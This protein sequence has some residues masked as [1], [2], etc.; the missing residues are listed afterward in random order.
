MAT[1]KLK[2]SILGLINRSPMS[3]YDLRKYFVESLSHFWNAEFNQIYTELRRLQEEG[4]VEFDT[5]KAGEKLEKKVYRI[6]EAGHKD[7]MDWLFLDEPL[8]P[9]RADS[10][11]LR[12]YFSENLSVEELEKLFNAQCIRHWAVL[13]EL[14]DS[15]Y[16]IMRAEEM[17]L[18]QYSE[19]LLIEGGI[20][21]EEAYIRWLHQCAERMD[22]TLDDSRYAKMRHARTE[23]A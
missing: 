23:S 9:Q 12:V 22:F 8:P 2:Y 13:L 4:L 1:R 19:H 7:F 16:S 5:V 3:G 6:T 17:D 18:T 15:L 20:L 14:E 10:F 11:R 21:R